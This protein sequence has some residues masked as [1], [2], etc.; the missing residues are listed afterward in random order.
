M[1][2]WF[3]R[4]IEI[5]AYKWPQVMRHQGDAIIMHYSDDWWCLVEG[6]TIILHGR[7]DSYRCLTED[8]AI[9]ILCWD[10]T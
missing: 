9:I 10:D 6:D 5:I 2:S 8:D 4:Q 3:R 7:D 1:E